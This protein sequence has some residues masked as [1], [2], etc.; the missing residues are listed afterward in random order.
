[1][2]GREGNTKEGVGITGE[3]GNEGRRWTGGKKEGHEGKN[4]ASRPDYFEPKPLSTQN[5]D[6]LYTR[7]RTFANT[8]VATR[9]R[10]VHIHI[11]VR[12]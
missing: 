8:A 11:H 3:R 10:F 5:R 1:M 4:G 9:N 2:G 6:D 7:L 12:A